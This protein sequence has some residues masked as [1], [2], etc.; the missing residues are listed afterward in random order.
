MFL[1]IFFFW[2]VVLLNGNWD[3]RNKIP[4]I[5][6]EMHE[7]KMEDIN[8]AWGNNEILQSNIRSQINMNNQW[9]QEQT[10]LSS[11]PQGSDSGLG[12]DSPE[13]NL[14]WLLNFKLDD[15]PGLPGMNTE[16]DFS[17]SRLNLEEE[18]RNLVSDYPQPQQNIYNGQRKVTATNNGHRTSPVYIQDNHN[19]KTQF[20]YDSQKVQ[21]V[22]TP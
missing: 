1:N 18:M 22:S 7:V 20:Q 5:V 6:A 2:K 21:N 3:T 13:G 19:T 9:V 15:L 16:E 8:T 14:S 4:N 12:N 17:T 11:S 10:G